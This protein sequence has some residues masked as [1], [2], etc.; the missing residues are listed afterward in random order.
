MNPKPNNIYGRGNQTTLPR[1]RQRRIDAKVENFD[2]ME[3]EKENLPSR[4]NNTI[5]QKTENLGTSVKPSMDLE[6]DED[7]EQDIDL[8]DKRLQET[9]KKEGNMENIS[10]AVIQLL[11]K[12]KVNK[13]NAFEVP[14]PSVTM[15]P[16]FMSNPKAKKHEGKMTLSFF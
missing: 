10:K 14:I 4:Q 7:E 1:N 5:N 6:M 2:E 12:N 16:E 15:L 8:S 9:M 13:N 11:L 3:E